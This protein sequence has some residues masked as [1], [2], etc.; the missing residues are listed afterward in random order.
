[1]TQFGFC[2]CSAR[3]G[4]GFGAPRLL[5]GL[6][7]VLPS[8]SGQAVPHGSRHL[9]RVQQSQIGSKGARHARESRP[10]FPQRPSSSS[11]FCTGGTALPEAQ[12]RGEAAQKEGFI[13]AERLL[14][15]PGTFLPVNSG[16]LREG[17]A[18]AAQKCPSE[19]EALHQGLD[20]GLVCSKLAGLSEDEGEAGKGPG[21]FIDPMA[22]TEF[23]PGHFPKSSKT[24]PHR[25]YFRGAASSL[26]CFLSQGG[27]KEESLSAPPPR[28]PCSPPC[29]RSCPQGN[30]SSSIPRHCPVYFSSNPL[31]KGNKCKAGGGN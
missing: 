12:L 8:C 1:M 25:N 18:K 6:R 16:G 19:L 17:C 4:N 22:G 2:D 5:L 20:L 23:I 28:S 9:A 14:G 7:R 31:V 29:S 26:G 10:S 27:G 15:I 21:W 11:H 30:S 24:H 13:P 3:G